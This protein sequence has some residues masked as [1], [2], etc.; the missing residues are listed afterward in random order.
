MPKAEEIFG[1]FKIQAQL[2]I[3]FQIHSQSVHGNV[4]KSSSGQGNTPK[5]ELALVI[6]SYSV[7]R[8]LFFIWMI[9]KGFPHTLLLLVMAV[10]CCWSFNLWKHFFQEQLSDCL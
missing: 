9:K 2:V 6:N 10:S 7:F 4:K 1:T 8:N 5:L 3:P